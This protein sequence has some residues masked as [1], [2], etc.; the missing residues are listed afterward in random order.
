MIHA[1]ASVTPTDQADEMMARQR[2]FPLRQAAAI[3]AFVGIA[4]LTLPAA[5]QEKYP[6]RPVELIVPFAAGG[7]TDILARLLTDGLTRRLGQ[8]FLVINRPGANT[9][10]GTGQ[11]A[12]AKPDG[13]TLLMTSFGLAANPSLYRNLG[14]DPAKDLTPISL[15]AN[16]PTILVVHPSF[17]AIKLQEFTAHL[18]ANP[19]KFNY[20]SYGVGSSPHIGA[21]LYK[22]LTGTEIV[23]VPFNGGGPAAAAVAGKQVEMLFPSAV[24]VQGLIRNGS[25][26]PIAV[27]SSK[28]T[29]LLP[30]LPTFREGGLD[31]ITGSWFGVLA[32][33][34]T[35]QPI[36]DLLHAN[37]AE[38]LKDNALRTKMA[39]QGADVIGNSPEEF[40]TFLAT[41]TARLAKV[42]KNAKIQLD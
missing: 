28:R 40:R 26:K 19:G 8:T 5:S 3:A 38:V 31:Y 14:F 34:K 10:L 37:I 25:L 17:P 16:A 12:R 6:S 11:V 35:P 33:A 24:P 18:K 13:Y 1:Q 30:D 41:E 21:E 20:A 39:E 27:A 22:L 42:I 23:H 7:G 29:A 36:I 15:L 32:P 2:S 9:N 4:A